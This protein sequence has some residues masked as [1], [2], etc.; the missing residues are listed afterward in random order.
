MTAGRER[1]GRDQALEWASLTPEALRDEIRS[2]RRA[3]LRLMVLIAEDAK[4][5]PRSGATG[6]AALINAC[7]HRCP[8]NRKDIHWPARR[9]PA[10]ES[11]GPFR[12]AGPV[13]CW[14]SGSRFAELDRSD[15]F[16]CLAEFARVEIRALARVRDERKVT[17]LPDVP[18]AHEIIARL[19]AG[20]HQASRR[21]LAGPIS[22]RSEAARFCEPVQ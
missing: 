11:R 19:K 21:T 3:E 14:L 9:R 6:M 13:Q 18:H 12:R 1:R 20:R 4:P 22:W 7:R 17:V 10:F 5:R 15:N 16:L 2:N 8:A